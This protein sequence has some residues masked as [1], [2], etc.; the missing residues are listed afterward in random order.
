MYSTAPADW[1]TVYVSNKVEVDPKLFILVVFFLRSNK[2]ILSHLIRD[3]NRYKD[4]DRQREIDRER[5]RERERERGSV[6]ILQY[7]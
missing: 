7:V 6:I 5:E 2:N 1:A 3:R 4:Y